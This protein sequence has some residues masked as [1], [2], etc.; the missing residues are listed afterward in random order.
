MVK[1][2]VRGCGMVCLR[3][4]S[5]HFL[6]KEEESILAFSSSS[7]EECTYRDSKLRDSKLDLL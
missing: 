4:A 1:G 3:C 7:V 6:E 5:G 2:M